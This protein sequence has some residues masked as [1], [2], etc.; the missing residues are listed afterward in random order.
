MNPLCFIETPFLEKFGVPRQSL[1]VPEAKGILRFPKTDFFVESFRG[2]EESSHLWLIF[3]FNQIPEHEI[4]ALVRPPRYCGKKKVGVFASRS[5]HRPNRLGLS[6]VKF[7]SFKVLEN[8]IELEVTG[9]DLVN[10]TPIYDIKPYVPYSDAIKAFSPFT[11]P[12]ES[13][14]VVW[15][16]ARPGAAS[17][18]EKVISLD[19][20]PGHDRESSEEFGVAI[21][22]HNIRFKF[23][24]D[25]FVIVSAVKLE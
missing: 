6:V 21:A 11:S 19:P 9:V 7:E 24:L 16:C 10:G 15:D 2:I 13:Y 18:I 12:D 23:L 22:G 1:L 25:H 14:P 8:V 20:R 3:E 4:K 5:P 17:L